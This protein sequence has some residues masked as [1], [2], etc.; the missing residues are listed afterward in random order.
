MNGMC[1]QETGLEVQLKTIQ[2]APRESLH[3]LLTAKG[4]KRPTYC[5]Q[6]SIT[7]AV[8]WK[9]TSVLLA[10]KRSITKV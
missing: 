5:G 7:S 1:L 8:S 4:Q 3:L 10:T 2:Q 9:M 6:N